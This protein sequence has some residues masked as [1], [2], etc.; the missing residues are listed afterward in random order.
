MKST[1]K[2]ITSQI[3]QFM[4]EFVS[5]KKVDGAIVMRRDGLI[6]SE[7]LNDKYD[8]KKLATIFSS[9][10]LNGDKI[11]NSTNYGEIENIIVDAEDNFT[12]SKIDNDNYLI[13][14]SKSDVDYGAVII[15]LKAVK[16]KI[17]EI[18]EQIN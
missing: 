7:E 18:I 16:R 9:I 4:E 14:Q 15:L 11:S 13:A 6:V 5:E 1:N 12:A 3:E 2:S 8:G 10:I 17:R